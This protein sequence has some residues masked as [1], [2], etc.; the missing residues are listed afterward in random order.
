MVVTNS[1]A[2]SKAQI[3]KDLNANSGFNAVT[4]ASLQGNQVTIQS[5][6]NSATSSIAIPPTALATSL[7][8]SSTTATGGHASTGASLTLRR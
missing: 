8:L 3:V 7:G 1:A 2:T 4:T 5:N 6:N